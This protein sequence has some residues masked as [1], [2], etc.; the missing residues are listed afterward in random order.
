MEIS[1]LVGTGGRSKT[2]LVTGCVEDVFDIAFMLDGYYHQYKAEKPHV[3]VIRA[4][5]PVTVFGPDST[6]SKVSN[7]H[8]SPATTP[9]ITLTSPFALSSSSEGQ[10]PRYAGPHLVPHQGWNLAE[11][12]VGTTRRIDLGQVPGNPVARQPGETSAKGGR[13]RGV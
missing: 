7:N 9:S 5:E 1:A 4:A 8:A 10:P 6:T 12:F 11:A 13:G 2:M 3:L